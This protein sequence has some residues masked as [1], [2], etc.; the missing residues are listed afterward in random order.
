MLSKGACICYGTPS[1]NVYTPPGLTAALPQTSRPKHTFKFRGVAPCAA[2][3]N[4]RSTRALRIAASAEAPAQTWKA[5]IDFKNIREN[6]DAIEENAK[7]RASKV[8]VQR[9]AELYD[10]YLTVKAETDQL[11]AARNE[12]AAKMKGKME[13]DARQALIDE[14]KV[15]KEK[16]SVL[17]EKLSVVETD[18][19]REGQ[20]IP[21][22]SH[23]DVPIGG[24][25]NAT[26]RKMVGE[27]RDFGFEFKDHVALGESLKM[28]DFERASEVSGNKF[29]YLRNAGALL[30]LALVNWAMTKVVSRGFSPMITPDLVRSSVVEKCGFQP[31]MANTQVGEPCR[32]PAARREST[33]SIEW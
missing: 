15:L 2:P 12:N 22:A 18:M 16:I 29:L 17:E 7:A 11:R 8:D 9:V 25:E 31:R 1:L 6:V 32:E 26:L 21:N 3:G 10:E 23:P 33:H 4:I 14:G 5:S 24:E 28:I 30:E 20:K 27:Q 19:Q 13:Q